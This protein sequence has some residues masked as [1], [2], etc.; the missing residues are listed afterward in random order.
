MRFVP[1]AARLRSLN[2]GEAGDEHPTVR[3]K[4]ANRIEMLK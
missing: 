2:Y 4:S 3:N 1:E